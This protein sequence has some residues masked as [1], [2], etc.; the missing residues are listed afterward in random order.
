MKYRSILS[1]Y[2][3][4]LALA[5][6]A[7][8]FLPVVAFG[9]GAIIGYVWGKTAVTNTQLEKLTHIMVVDLYMDAN[10]N[11]FPNPDFPN[12]WVSA[13]LDPLINNA[14]NN[15]YWADYIFYPS[16]YYQISCRASNAC[17]V[18]TNFAYLSVNVSDGYKSYPNP[19]S[20]ILNIEIDA[21]KSSDMSGKT[22]PNIDFRLYDDKG[23]LLRQTTSNGGTVQF[24]VSNLPNGSYYLHIY[25]GVNSA[26]IIQ[27]IMVEH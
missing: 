10:G 25:D 18:G 27:Q 21:A 24:N 22:A 7:I 13:W 15:G 8:L 17:G 19:A 1:K 4:I 11:V 3:A 16:G 12:N 9:K 20:D 2:T 5:V 6:S 14:H 26:P 23:N